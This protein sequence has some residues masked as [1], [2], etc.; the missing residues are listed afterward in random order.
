MPILYVF[1]MNIWLVVTIEGSRARGVIF[2][3][4]RLP[5]GPSD[6]RPPVMLG[7]FCLIPKVTVHDRYY[8][9][10]HSILVH[11]GKLFSHPSGERLR[12][13]ACKY[14]T[15]KHVWIRYTPPT[16]PYIPKKFWKISKVIN[17]EFLY[18]EARTKA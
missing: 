8:C 16:H 11:S 3:V 5:T 15:P 18:I 4:L 6:E 2:G 12:G 9:I 10:F 13:L 7:H 1:S 14:K 17:H